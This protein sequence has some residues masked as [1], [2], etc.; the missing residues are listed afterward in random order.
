VQK[1]RRPAYEEVQ[2]H[3]DTTLASDTSHRSGTATNAFKA[4]APEYLRLSHARSADSAS[5]LTIISSVNLASAPAALQRTI[6]A[7]L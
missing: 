7:V 4:A 2:A 5:R 1:K 6:S 3:L